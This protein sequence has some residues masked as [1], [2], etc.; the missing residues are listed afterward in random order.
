MPTSNSPKES[1]CEPN[2][3]ISER[4]KLPLKLVIPTTVLAIACATWVARIERG[5]AA[6]SSFHEEFRR[7]LGE[8]DVGDRFKGA[9]ADRWFER[10]QWAWQFYADSEGLSSYP[11]VPPWREG[12]H[13]T[14]SVIK[15]KDPKNA[16]QKSKR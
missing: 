16:E 3:T 14:P 8:R 2:G 9:D 7:V 12:T 15:L 5:A 11:E 4:T 1:S 13:W 10:I 6:C